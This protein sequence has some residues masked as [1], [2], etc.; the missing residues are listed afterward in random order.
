M[1]I[2]FLIAKLERTAGC[3]VLYKFMDKLVE[4]GHEVFVVTPSGSFQWEQNKWS[5]FLY[6]SNK[7]KSWHRLYDFIENFKIKIKKIIK[8][9]SKIKDKVFLFS[10]S[11]LTKRLIKNWVECDIT[12]GTF[13]FT[14]YAAF[15][16]SDKTIPVAYVQGFEELFFKDFLPRKAARLSHYLIP[17]LLV[18]CTWLQKMI[19]SH[20]EIGSKV[21]CPAI[22]LGIFKPTK[23]LHQ[24][25]KVKNNWTILSYYNSL[26]EKG[27]RDSVQAIHKAKEKL[28]I[29]AIELEW[30]VF[31]LM[32]PLESFNADC[33]YVGKAFNEDLAELYASADI[34]LCP[35]WFDS[36]PFPPLE[37][38]STGTIVVTTCLGTED[39]ALNGVNSFVVNPRD[40]DAMAERI[41]YIVK[42]PNECISVAEK[43]LETAKRFF[44]DIQTDLLEQNLVDILNGSKNKKH[45]NDNDKLIM[46]EFKL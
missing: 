38:M 41:M 31:G 34:V 23:S 40:E 32:A 13:C 39:Y 28:K 29:C 5:K 24:K 19:M 44:W 15:L 11:R 42:N 30:K 4:R 33:I 37:A 26:E 22:D 36:F 45:I 7:S 35:S 16:L 17:H 20:Y 10:I 12:I 46:G 2:S 14:F 3:L 8:N 21:V 25:Y 43:G 9:N 6:D 1:K 27:F 18:N